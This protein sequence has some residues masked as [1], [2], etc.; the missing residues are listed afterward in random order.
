MRELRHIMNIV[1]EVTIGQR[2]IDGEYLPVFYT[3]HYDDLSIN[4]FSSVRS[5]TKGH[6]EM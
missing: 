6:Q 3:L 1:A 2:L 4:M 5:A